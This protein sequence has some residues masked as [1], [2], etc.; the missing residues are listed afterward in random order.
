M[1]RSDVTDGHGT[2][3]EVQGLQRACADRV[4]LKDGYAKSLRSIA[5]FAFG[6]EQ[7]GAIT[8]A[9]AVLLDAANLR[10]IAS[11]V[12]RAPTTIAHGLGPPGFGALPALLA[13]NA[14]LPQRPDLAFVHGHGTAHPHR[15]GIAVHFAVATDLPSIG[16][17]EEILVGDGIIPHPTRGAYTALRDGRGQVGWLLRSQVDCAPLVVSPAHRVALASSADLVMRYVTA[18][19][20]PEPL[21]L[22]DALVAGRDEA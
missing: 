16:V 7:A 13:V 17:A 15:A 4:L 2:Q 9:A 14:L 6:F 10:P 3:D 19:R 18:S 8:C 21:R 11:R 20:W 5:G 12:A 22:A 1:V